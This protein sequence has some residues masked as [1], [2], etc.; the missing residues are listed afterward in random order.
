MARKSSTS[1][2]RSST[3]NRRRAQRDQH[4]APW[5]MWSLGA[6]I[7]GAF[8]YFLYWL[9]VGTPAT[10]LP[11]REKEIIAKPA[12][13]TPEKK[14]EPRF[15]FYTI[16]PEKEVIV[17]EGEVK[18]RKR[19]EHLGQKP[20]G[21][22]FIQAGSFRTHADADRL[23]AQLALLGVQARIEQ[24][25]VKGSVWHRV[26]MGPFASMTEVESLRSRLRKHRIDSV[27]QTAKR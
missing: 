11:K 10:S 17:P 27:V 13:K 2:R 9:S 22:Y 15:T 4:A 8:G 25:K 19:Q 5:W 26:R 3:N 23:K 14:K 24:A 1:R 16:L 12:A 7:L 21:H 20:S 18:V 6:L